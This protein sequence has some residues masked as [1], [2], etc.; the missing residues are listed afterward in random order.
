MFQQVNIFLVL[1]ALELKTTIQ[2]GSHK[3]RIET[4]FKS[5]FFSITRILVKK[6]SLSF[7]VVSTI[8][9]LSEQTETLWSKFCEQI[10]FLPVQDWTMFFSQ[11]LKKVETEKDGEFSNCL[12]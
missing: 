10:R 4:E 7:K 9:S 3:S 1:G 8:K 12:K 6:A 11:T 5:V 2:V